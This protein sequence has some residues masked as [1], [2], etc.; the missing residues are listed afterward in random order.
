MFVKLLDILIVTMPSIVG[1]LY[2]LTS[3]VYLYKRDYAWALVWFSYAMA[4]VGL[5]LIGL[6]K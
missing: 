3:F 2:F 4:N 6:K 5:V 1:A